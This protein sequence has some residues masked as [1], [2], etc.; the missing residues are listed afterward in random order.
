MRGIKILA[1]VAL[2]LGIVN[3]AKHVV[4]KGDTLWDLS[5]H[6]LKDPFQ[7]PGIWRINPQVKNPH[8][9]YPG[10]IIQLPGSD[11]SAAKAAPEVAHHG[12]GDDPLAGFP[13][14]PDHQK[15]PALRNS[16]EIALA[17]A[18]ASRQLEPQTVLLAPVWSLDTARSGEDKI[19]WERSGGFSMLLPGRSIHV[20]IGCRDSV[21][22]GD[23]LEVIET[24]SEVATIVKPGLAG[25]LE[26]LR[27][28]LTVMEV[29]DTSAYCRVNRVYGNVT[30]AAKVRKA[31]AVATREIRGFSDVSSSASKNGQGCAMPDSNFVA[32]TIAN[33]SNSTLQMPGNYIVLD[34]GQ[35]AGLQQGDVVAFMDATLPHGQEAAR[36]YGIVVRS[37]QGRASVLLAGVDDQPVRLGDKA[38]VIRRALA[39]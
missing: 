32:K 16:E 8:W 20:A 11:D 12:A 37:S 27:A 24:G 4:V 5:G 23:I 31:R 2:A 17:S 6:Y 13:L 15:P 7:W 3:A 18:S 1:V 33:T 21:K 14:G 26:Q 29:S 22:A 34:R 19:L 30:M 9:I 28:Y 36:G 10:D 38:Y 39:D 35:E 25:R